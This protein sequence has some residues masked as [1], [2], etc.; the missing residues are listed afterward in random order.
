LP[1]DKGVQ[2]ASITTYSGLRIGEGI[3]WVDF[4]RLQCLGFHAG[5]YFRVFGQWET[6]GMMELYRA[7]LILDDLH[8]VCYRVFFTAALAR[9]F[10]SNG[11]PNKYDFVLVFPLGSG[12]LDLFENRFQHFF[13]NTPDFATVVDPPPFLSTIASDMKWLLAASYVMITAALCIRAIVV[14]WVNAQA[15]AK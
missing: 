3:G 13:L 4:L 9:L 14:R 10:D 6:D 8:W 2:V 12:L 1:N 11:I 7:H 15:L 5:D